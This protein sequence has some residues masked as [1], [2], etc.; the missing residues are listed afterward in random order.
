M[1][2]G[3][4]VVQF[5]MGDVLRPHDVGQQLFTALRCMDALGVDAIIVEV[6]GRQ[7]AGCGCGLPRGRGFH[8]VR[9]RW[10]FVTG[11]CGVCGVLLP[12]TQGSRAGLS[13]RWSC[14]IGHCNARL[15]TH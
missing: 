4:E 15:H 6:G 14:W 1:C 12:S 7:A 8:A 9:E 13:P 3:V 5:N 2:E 10:D 11:F